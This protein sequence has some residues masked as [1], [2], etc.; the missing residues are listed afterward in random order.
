MFFGEKTEI[1]QL[2]DQGDKFR[3]LL[4]TEWEV[5]LVDKVLAMEGMRRGLK[6]DIS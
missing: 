3:R 6:W 5:S 4:Q 2:Y 1:E